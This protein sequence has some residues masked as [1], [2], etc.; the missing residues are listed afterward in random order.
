[1]R[2]KDLPDLLSLQKEG[3]HSLFPQQTKITVGM[4]TCGLAS[5]AGSVINAIQDEI[6]KKDLNFLVNGT[7]C[8][9]LCQKEPFVDIIKPGWPRIVRVRAGTS[10]CLRRRWKR[11]LRGLPR[12]IRDRLRT[13]RRPIRPTSSSCV[14]LSVARTLRRGSLRYINVP[15]PAPR[16]DVATCSS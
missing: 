9:G 13:I 5:G 2:V 12:R 4:A 11:G 3:L 7:G 15:T 10:V 8:M 14:A 1:M 6:R 16:P